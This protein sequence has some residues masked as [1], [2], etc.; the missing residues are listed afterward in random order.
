[1]SAP[2]PSLVLLVD[3]YDDARDMLRFLL[4]ARG[5]RTVEAR[6]GHEAIRQAAAHR[7]DA[8]VMDIFMPNLDGLEATRRIKA[9]PALNHIPI[10]ACTARAEHVRVDPLFAS[11]LAKPCT[12]ERVLAALSAALA[13][14]PPA[15]VAS[16]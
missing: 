12:P 10:I 13:P 8:I 2:D 11:C 14:P 15:A 4:E 1:L 3:D 6:D 7:P 16:R 5:Y 9:D